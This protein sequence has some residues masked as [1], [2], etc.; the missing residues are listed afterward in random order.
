MTPKQKFMKVF[1]EEIFG[2]DDV[3]FN[4]SDCGMEVVGIYNITVKV[5]SYC[6]L[7]K[8]GTS[9]Q[10]EKIPM[11]IWVDKLK[12]G[13]YSIKFKTCFNHIPYS[14]YGEVLGRV[15]WLC[16]N[17]KA[18]IYYRT[19]AYCFDPDGVPT[20]RLVVSKLPWE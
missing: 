9:I 15:K 2:F 12:E 6:V 1:L 3:T 10:R 14:R 20:L 5:P 13:G 8:P 19:H 4:G 7:M 11:R 17:V 18:D 16:P